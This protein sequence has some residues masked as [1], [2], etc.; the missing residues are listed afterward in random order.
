MGTF[1]L[2]ERKDKFKKKEYY[3]MDEKDERI[4]KSK[5]TQPVVKKDAILSEDFV[6]TYRNYVNHKDYT[7]LTDNY[8]SYGDLN[9]QQNET[10][11]IYNIP[12]K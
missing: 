11:I 2:E 4:L 7:I 6:N 1:I 9:L 5:I 8:T 3:S 10:M 12:G